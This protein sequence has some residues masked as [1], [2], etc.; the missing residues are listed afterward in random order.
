MS[1]QD[2]VWLRRRAAAARQLAAGISDKLAIEGLLKHA[3][4]LEAMASELEAAVP[5]LPAAATTQSGEPP[6]GPE[7]AAALKPPT[8][9]PEAS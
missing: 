2:V 6:I 7:A 8:S 3:A 1:A 5:V 9:E 4:E